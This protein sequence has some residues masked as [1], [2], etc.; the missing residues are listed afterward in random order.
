MAKTVQ[1]LHRAVHKKASIRYSSLHI[2]CKR[3]ISVLI[4][5]QEYKLNG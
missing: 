1:S 5:F 3:A 2:K 4:V